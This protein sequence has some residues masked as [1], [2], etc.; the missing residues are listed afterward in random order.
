M[1]KVTCIDIGM[2]SVKYIE[3]NHPDQAIYFAKQDW[4]QRFF[5]L[6]V[7]DH[8][9]EWKAEKTKEKSPD[10]LPLY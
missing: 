1:F 4:N 5:P 7:D 2:Q 6:N 3:A 10:F 9:S 8:T